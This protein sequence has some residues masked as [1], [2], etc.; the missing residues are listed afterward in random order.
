MAI[1]SPPRQYA[2]FRLVTYALVTATLVMFVPLWAPIVLAVW[3]AAMARP[4]V[5]RIAHAIGG[6]HRAAGA[7][8]ALLV[9]VTFIPF[10]VAVISLT[11]GI[12]DL[13]TNVIHSGGAKSALVSVVSGGQGGASLDVLKSPEKIIGLVREHGDQALTILGGI[14]GAATTA[15]IGLFVFFLAVYVFLVDGPSQYE[16]IEKHS[17]LDVEHMRRFVSAFHETG[18]GLFVGI[19]LTGLSQGLVATAAYLALGVPRALVLGFL[20]C[21]ASLLPS[22][23]TALVWVP[24]AAGLAFAGKTGSALI[25][26]AVGVVAISTIDNV[27]RPVFARFGKLELSTFVL[28]T[29]IFGALV[30]IGPWGIIAGPLLAR[31]AKEALVMARVDRL[32]EKR[33]EV[34]DEKRKRRGTRGLDPE[35]A[36]QREQRGGMPPANEGALVNR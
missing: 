3:V 15:A 13:V 31:L 22:V 17:P 16:W 1:L 34:D 20:T 23:G 19:G 33:R 10:A 9:L 7:L 28:L 4:L 27:L 14:A 11:R 6:R 35:I 36:G 21:I 32:R 24:V 30:V 5:S 18:R 25:L 8:V 12:S 2:A 29:S 26:C